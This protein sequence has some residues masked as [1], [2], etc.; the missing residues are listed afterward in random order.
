MAGDPR[1]QQRREASTVGEWVDPRQGSWGSVLLPPPPESHAECLRL[2]RAF[3][4]Q[5]F[6]SS[7]DT[8]AGRLRWEVGS[9]PPQLPR[10]A[11]GMW[12]APSSLVRSVLAF[13]IIYRRGN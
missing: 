2:P 7:A 8:E 1:E 3:R 6:R 11:E 4:P 13:P 12:G 10:N 9:C 5:L